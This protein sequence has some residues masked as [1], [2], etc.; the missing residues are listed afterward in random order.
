MSFSLLNVRSLKNKAAQVNQYIVD[1]K[2]DGLDGNV[3]FVG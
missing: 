1:N 2:I 3:G